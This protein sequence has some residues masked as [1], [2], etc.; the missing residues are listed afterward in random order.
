M[1]EDEFNNLP[2]NRMKVLAAD[3]DML[4]DLVKRSKRELEMIRMKDSGA[5]YDVGLR[6]DLTGAI[7]AKRQN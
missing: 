5:V 4:L 3:R 6:T 1:T 2:S 7:T